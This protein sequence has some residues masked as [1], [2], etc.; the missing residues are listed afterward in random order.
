MQANDIAQSE[1]APLGGLRSFP[2]GAPG[3]DAAHQVVFLCEHHYKSA[4]GRCGGW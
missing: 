2:I 1:E 4:T 3:T